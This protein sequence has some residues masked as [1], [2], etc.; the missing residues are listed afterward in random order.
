VLSDADF[1]AQECSR[2]DN[3]ARGQIIRPLQREAEKWLSLLLSVTQIWGRI[4]V[5]FSSVLLIHP[6]NLEN[7]LS[8]DLGWTIPKGLGKFLLKFS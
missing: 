4:F 5:L 7:V 6:Y 1:T 2:P 8:W 3:P